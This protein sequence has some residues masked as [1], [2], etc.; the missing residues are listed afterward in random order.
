MVGVVHPAYT[1]T[2]DLLDALDPAVVSMTHYPV[3]DNEDF[4]ECVRESRTFVTSL[5]AI[6]HQL[7]EDRAPL[8]LRSAIDATV[9]RLGSRG[10]DL[11]Y[12]MPLSAHLTAHAARGTFEQTAID[13]KP[14][15][16]LAE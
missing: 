14:A 1:R 8:T 12:A 15:W 5:D 9:D 11:D 4:V 6:V 3:L 13:G 7:V 2:I 16:T 10:L